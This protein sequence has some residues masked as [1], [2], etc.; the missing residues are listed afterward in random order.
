[1]DQDN[2]T[3]AL[4]AITTETE[5]NEIISLSE[6]SSQSQAQSSLARTISCSS[7][8][9]IQGKPKAPFDEL[10][11]YNLKKDDEIITTLFIEI[12]TCILPRYSCACHK[13]NIAVRAAIKNHQDLAKDLKNL[14]K[15]AS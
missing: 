12:G 2:D 8:T 5:D 15:F 11:E 4:Q 9:Q 6:Q 10:D 7:Q 14:S 13:G 3:D 1:L